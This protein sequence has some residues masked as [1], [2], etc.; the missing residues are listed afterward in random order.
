MFLKKPLPLL[1]TYLIARSV[2]LFISKVVLITRLR[3]K[4]LPSTWPILRWI[5]K[6]PKKKRFFFISL[7]SVTLSPYIYP[8]ATGYIYGDKVTDVRLIKKNL[9]FLGAFPIHLKIG[10]VD[11]SNFRRSRV[12]K[13]TLDINKK[14]DL[15]IKYVDNSGK[16]F[17]KNNVA[18]NRNYLVAEFGYKF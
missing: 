1:S 12:I 17:F 15:A 3:L 6:A 10:Q 16:G 8:V 14:T 7:T 9:F 5:G 18:Q 13:T 2:F 4:L 11:G